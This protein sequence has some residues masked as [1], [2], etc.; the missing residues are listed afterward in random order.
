M[1]ACNDATAAAGPPTGRFSVAP[2]ESGQ[3]ASNRAPAVDEDADGY[4]AFTGSDSAARGTS[5][6]KSFAGLFSDPDGDTLTYTVSVPDDRTSLVDELE[7][8]TAQ[9]RVNF[10]YDGDDD[11]KNAVP[12]IA[13]PLST[14]VTLTATDPGGLSVTLKGTFQAD[15]ESHPKLRFAD[16]YVVVYELL[17]PSAQGDGELPPDTAEVVLT[18]DQ[19]LQTSPAPA[20]SQFTVKVFNSDESAAGTIAVSSVAITG[21]KVSLE[22]ESAP[23]SGQYLTLDYT[24]DDDKPIKRAA[25]GGDSAPGFTG[26]TVWTLFAVSEPPAEQGGAD[27]AGGRCSARR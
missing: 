26:R 1:E 14:E 6:S 17:D 20:A 4:D 19:D 13:N 15:W 27:T 16:A 22:L 25:E 12:A 5:V 8:D 9:S 3:Q 10:K 24:H 18:F 2:L 7:V 21:K 23:E 11:W